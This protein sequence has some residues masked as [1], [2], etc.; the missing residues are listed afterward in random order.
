MSEVANHPKFDRPPVIEVVHGVRFRRL[1]INIAHPGH[2]QDL[3]KDR[4]PG[5]QTVPALPPEREYFGTPQF[6]ALRFE[7]PLLAELPRAWFISADETMLIQLQSDRLLLNWRAG[8]K[9]DIYPAFSAISAEFRR[10]L[11]TLVEFAKASGLGS[12]DTEQCEMAYINQMG[13]WLHDSVMTPHEWLRGWSPDLGPDWVGEMEDFSS[14]ARFALRRPDG[15]AYGRVTANATTVIMPPSLDRSLQFDISVRG[16]PNPT[17]I[18]GILE[19][20]EMAHD[21]IVRCFAAM[22]TTSAHDYWGR[23]PA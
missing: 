8:P 10:V 21:Q 4:Y 12:V 2:F 13:T 9:K 18:D 16:I 15:Q 5:V 20:H 17:G 6:A 3:L 22:T 7:I 23:R 14:V 19:F 11:E 1:N